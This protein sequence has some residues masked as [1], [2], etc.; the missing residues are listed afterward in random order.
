M[1]SDM[2]RF[3]TVVGAIY[4]AALDV[5]SWDDALLLLVE[6][7]APLYWDVAF[8]AWERAPNPGA[9]F[10]AAASVAPHARELYAMHFAGRNPWSLRIAQQPVGR[11]LDTDDICPRE[12]LYASDLYKHFLG[13]WSL[14]RAVAVVLDR[15]RDERLALVIAGPEGRDISGLQRA[16]RL[17]APHLQRAVRISR[18]IAAADLRA[19]AAEAS[20]NASTAGVVALRR[21]LSVVNANTR[22]VGYVQ[23]GVARMSDQRWRFASAAA[24]HELE[25]LARAGAPTSAAFSVSTADGVEHAV[26][27]ARIATQGAATLDGFLEGAAILLTIGPKAR[28][29]TIPLD[30]LAAWYGFT[31]T[32]ALLAAALADGDTIAMFAARRAVS[33][34]AVRF[35]LR[36]VFR[37]TDT[38]DQARLVAALRA[39]PLA[40]PAPA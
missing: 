13:A 20:L 33:Q 36:G 15:E 9:R 32:E 30:H 27:A 17:L 5:A 10:V 6:T 40:A 39:L 18:R 24:Q 28:A 19:G 38:G 14:D 25:R 29:P 12:E 7:Y 22:A 21:D 23:D 1:S 4:E 31:P 8:L 2:E 11:V 3:S 16:L 37:K 26:L 35:V 34:N